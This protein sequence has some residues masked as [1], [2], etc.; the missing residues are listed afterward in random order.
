MTFS[1]MSGHFSH[2]NHR[3][4]NGLTVTRDSTGAAVKGGPDPRRRIICS[5]PSVGL[6]CCATWAGVS[7]SGRSSSSM[8]TTPVYDVA[9]RSHHDLI[10]CCVRSCCRSRLGDTRRRLRNPA[11]ASRNHRRLDGVA[12]MTVHAMIKRGDLESIRFGKHATMVVVREPV[13]EKEAA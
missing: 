1:V 9:P 6:R 5:A 12:E 11:R 13:S 10:V 8:G 7:I 4:L 3:F 2:K